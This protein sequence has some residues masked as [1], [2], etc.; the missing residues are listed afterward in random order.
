M[1]K[2]PGKSMVGDFDVGFFLLFRY[3]RNR[4][5]TVNELIIQAGAREP[6]ARN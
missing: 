3:D 5:G 4:S 1:Q 6:A 2:S